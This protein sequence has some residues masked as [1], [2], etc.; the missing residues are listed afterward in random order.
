MT[1]ARREAIARATSA[2]AEYRRVVAET[3]ARCRRARLEYRRA[4][5]QASAVGVSRR[6]LAQAVGV[7]AS[8]VQQMLESARDA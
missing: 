3:D 7:S 1:D 4:L 8:R 2:A 6:A 5:R